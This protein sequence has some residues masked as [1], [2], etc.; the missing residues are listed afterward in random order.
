MNRKFYRPESVR[1]PQKIL[2]SRSDDR[3]REPGLGAKF[4][5]FVLSAI[6]LWFGYF[7]VNLIAASSKVITST[8]SQGAPFLSFVGNLSPAKLQGEGDGRINIL[9]LGIGGGNHPGGALTDTIAIF[10]LD[11]INKTAGLLSI[12]RD[13]RVDIPGYGRDKINVAHAIGERGKKGQGI[14]LA[15]KTV[16]KVFDLPI[17]Y[18]VRVDFE[19]FVKLVDTVDGVDL[20][21][22]KPINDPFYPD[23]DLSGYEPFK[24]EAGERHFDGKTALKYARSRETTSDFD[25]ARRQQQLIAALSKKALNLDVF[26][27]PARISRLI[28][29]VG[30]HVRTDL[31][32]REI[33]RLAQMAKDFKDTSIVTVVIDNSAQGPLVSSNDGGFYLDTKTGDYSELRR[34][35]HGLFSDPY[36]TKEKAKI[37]VKGMVK[38]G[39][40]VNEVASL[41]KRYG[42][43]VSRVVDQVDGQSSK[44]EIVDYSGGRKPFTIEFLSRRLEAKVT[45]VEGEETGAD[46]VVIVGSKYRIPK[47]KAV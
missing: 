24:V 23:S 21:V 42:Y 10:S 35:A 5:F 20:F 43:N 26:V 40:P 15:K 6:F 31:S 1:L 8:N 7:A 33:E 22:E 4:S 13:L 29:I 12:P 46:I 16:S 47:E 45:E 37:E 28:R 19:G 30:D 38:T 11:P 36:L 34:I 25:R 2:K 41:L 3:Q 44:A 27:N 14:S 32:L 9:I 39:G 17:H 18:A